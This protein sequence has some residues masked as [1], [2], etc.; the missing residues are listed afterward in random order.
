MWE[1]I[2][3]YQIVG[4][5]NEG[6]SRNNLVLSEH[7]VDIEDVAKANSAPALDTC[8]FLYGKCN[9]GETL[10]DNESIDRHIG[11]LE[12]WLSDTLGLSFVKTFEYRVSTCTE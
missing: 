2:K 9:T 8:G 3:P 10:A 11:A 4:K 6:Q 1:E 12:T 7:H 5:L